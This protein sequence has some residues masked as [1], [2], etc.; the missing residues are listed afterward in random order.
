M[1]TKPWLNLYPKGVPQEIHP[2]MHSSLVDMLNRACKKYSGSLCMESFGYQITY[3]QLNRLSDAFASYLQQRFGMVKGERFAI[4]LP[5]L[6]QYTVALWGALKAGLTVV[7]VN[8]LYTARELK[9]QLNDAGVTGILVLENFATV[10]EEVMRD[11]AVKHVITT[12]LG[13]CISCD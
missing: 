5:N 3:H 13:R 10:L 6:L 12:Q 9:H 4:M 1:T 2:G 11:T 7:N 8:P